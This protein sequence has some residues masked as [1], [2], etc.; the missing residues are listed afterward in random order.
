M[1]VLRRRIKDGIEK[2]FSKDVAVMVERLKVM[3]TNEKEL[4]KMTKDI[5][6]SFSKFRMYALQA[7]EAEKRL[8]RLSGDTEMNFRWIQETYTAIWKGEREA[9]LAKSALERVTAQ[10]AI[11]TGKILQAL[12]DPV[13]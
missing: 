10:L 4:T 2:T 7:E 5:G 11:P 9:D 6:L 8:I 12:R 1:G 13:L 3:E